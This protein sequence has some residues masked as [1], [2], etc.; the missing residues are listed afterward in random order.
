[1]N[2]NLRCQNG[3]NTALSATALRPVTETHPNSGLVY[4][5]YRYYDPSVQR[6]INRDLIEEFGGINL[7]GFVGNR[8]TLDE[9]AFGL[10]SS[11]M[12]SQACRRLQDRVNELA[13]QILAYASQGKMPPAT[14]MRLFTLLNETYDVLCKGPPPPT[15]DP[16]VCPTP[17]PISREPQPLAPPRP[18]PFAIPGYNPIFSPVN[19]IP[20]APGVPAPSQGTI[21]ATGIIAILGGIIISIPKPGLP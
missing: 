5:L 16:I 20:I 10:D 14:T 4:Y 21:I 2:G 8:P 19:S 17:G 11:D 1:V 9:D 13:A 3:T 15:P 6:W 7:Y 12:Q 18:P